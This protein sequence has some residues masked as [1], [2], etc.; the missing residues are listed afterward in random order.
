MRGEAGAPRLRVYAVL[1]GLQ[2]IASGALVAVVFPLFQQIVSQ[3][4][5]PQS[6][7]TSTVVAALCA[8]LAMQA[9]YWTRYRRTPIRAPFH[10]ALAG[11][12]LMFA[13]RVSFFFSAALFSAIFFRHVPQLEALPP[14][15]QGFAKAVGVMILLF[16]SFCYALELERLGRAVEEPAPHAK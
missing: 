9:C 10:N 13:S 16:A 2:T 6:L 4:G 14:P 3:S 12:A 11:H 7:E 15:G 5:Q 8:A 1:L